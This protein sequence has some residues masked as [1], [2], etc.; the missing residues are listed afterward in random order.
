M[1]A[2]I[3]WRI[4]ATYWRIRAYVMNTLARLAIGRARKIAER[5]LRAAD[6]LVQRDPTNQKYLDYQRKMRETLGSIRT[7]KA[8]NAIQQDRIKSG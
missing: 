1:G 2:A 4:V 3:Y 8:A 6:G 5:H 7:T